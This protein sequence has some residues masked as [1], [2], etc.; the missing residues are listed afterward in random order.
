MSEQPEIV[1]HESKEEERRAA[2]PTPADNEQSNGTLEPE[3]KHE[4]VEQ[5]TG[6]DAPETLEAQAT[7][8]AQ[9][10]ARPDNDA[11]SAKRVRAVSMAALCIGQ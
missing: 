8:E 1:S 2:S 4:K 3:T 10:E 11:E 7:K 5:T 6:N 9:E